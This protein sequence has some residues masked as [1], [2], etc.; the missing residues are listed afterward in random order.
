MKP[1]SNSGAA[2]SAS[3]SFLIATA[4]TTLSFS[5]CSI[6]SKSVV[7]SSA[8]NGSSFSIWI[9]SMSGNSAGSI[10]GR[11]KRWARTAETGKPS[12]NSSVAVSSGTASSSV[13]SLRT[14]H[15][16]FCSAER[17]KFQP[18]A[19][20]IMK[21]DGI[22]AS[23]LKLLPNEYLRMTNSYYLFLHYHLHKAR[24]VARFSGAHDAEDS[25]GTFEDNWVL[26]QRPGLEA[27]HSKCR[28]LIQLGVVGCSI[29]SIRTLAQL[30]ERIDR[31]VRYTQSA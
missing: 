15:E 14:F 6:S 22:P 12:T 18:C 29:D 10:L 21:I 7:T 3:C 8:A 20:G 27:E 4:E 23:I 1:R 16:P 31:I 30:Q 13:C 24:H 28:L 9:R 5:S 11:R 25:I 19:V 2:I 26:K 17:R